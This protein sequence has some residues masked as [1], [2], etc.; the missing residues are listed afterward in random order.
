M[1]RVVIYSVL[2]DV[3]DDFPRKRFYARL[4]TYWDFGEQTERDAQLVGF[5]K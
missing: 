2:G 3:M 5:Y 1:T 4:V